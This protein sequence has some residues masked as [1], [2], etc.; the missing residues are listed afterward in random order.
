M[1]AAK[2]KSA[3]EGASAPSTAA[4]FCDEAARLVGG[5]REALHGDKLINF[6]N[7]ADMW[8]ALFRIYC[9]TRSYTL[10]DDYSEHVCAPFTAG[11]V[12]DF[13]EAFKIARRHSGSFNPDDYI[14][15]AGY[16]GCAG[17]VRQ[18]EQEDAG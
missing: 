17:A 13:M 9:R 1:T 3:T 15:A 14:D 6:K 2:R 12:A 7:I 4:E 8:N 11:D 10:L 5:P 16:A 18:R